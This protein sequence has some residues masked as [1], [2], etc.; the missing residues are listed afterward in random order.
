MEANIKELMEASRT[1]EY[2][3]E[4]N[5]S[6]G[7]CDSG[8]L[9]AVWALDILEREY[10]SD[11]LQADT[12]ATQLLPEVLMSPSHS[13]CLIE[14]VRYALL[15]EDSKNRSGFV[16]IRNEMRNDLTD[17][18]Q[19]HSRLQL[20]VASLFAAAGATVIFEDKSV[21]DRP[22]DVLA[23][24]GD[25]TI[26]VETFGIFPDDQLRTGNQ[27]MDRYSDLITSLQW[28]YDV[29]PIGEVLD[30]Y[31][32][33]D[34]EV[35]K[36][37]LRKAAAQAKLTMAPAQ[38]NH[39]FLDLRFVPQSL[40]E[41]GSEWSIPGGDPVGWARTRTRLQQ[42]ALLAT[43]SGPTWLRV[44]I[45]DT[46]WEL[47]PWA[48]S[49]M[50]EKTSS[51]AA[52][53]REALSGIDGIRG[54]LFSNGGMTTSGTLMG[55]STMP[56]NGAIGM[57]RKLWALGSRECIIVQ[58]DDAAS[59]EADVWWQ[60]YDQEAAWFTDALKRQGFPPADELIRLRPNEIVATS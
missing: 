5:R 47:S 54:V 32:N 19:T 1:W 2:W 12:N 48:Q 38:A 40:V 16:Q 3:R 26:R 35:M 51:L 14:M 53:T 20:E 44:D 23:R 17:H 59:T 29:F 36:T 22:V 55:E 13:A 21:G 6:C 57:F 25:L 9:A 39:P 31:K 58:I 33:S 42:K 34:F 49:S 56:V 27:V 52:A 10:G 8:R 4:Q 11:W 43:R 37:E 18:R 7:R 45:M 30:G 24:L 46:M 41:G 50:F 15:L 60:I 28:E